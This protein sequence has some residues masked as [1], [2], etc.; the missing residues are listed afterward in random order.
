MSGDNL[1]GNF[2]KARRGR[3]LADEAGIPSF[4]RRRVPGLRRD[5][6]ARLAG[7]SQH[8]LTRLEQGKDRNPSAQV[9]SALAIALRL[10]RDETAHLYAL[11]DPPVAS[12]RHG[13]ASRDVQ[14]LI[15]SWSGTPAYV[16]SRRFDV[17]AANKLAMALSPIYTP[18]RNLVRDMFVDREVRMLF[19][20]WEE[21]A[22]QTAAALRAEADLTD[23]ATAELVSS[24]LEDSHFRGLWAN[25]D[26][27]PSRNEVK[28]FVHPSVGSLTLRRQALSIGGAEDQVIITYQ[29][30]PGSP[31][32]AALTS[33]LL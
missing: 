23:P 3:V 5:E 12:E 8:Y 18:G 4:G 27:R 22:A 13:E 28:R 19:P 10:N 2:L 16:R 11:A 9:L 6:L 25:H 24:M 31:S 20:D 17:L 32:E 21:I 15:D 26:V 14:Q 33:L 7:M 29:A 1:L 30:E